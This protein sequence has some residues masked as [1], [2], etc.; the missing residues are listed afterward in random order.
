MFVLLTNCTVITPSDG[1][2]VTV[3]S[4]TGLVN[5]GSFAP[6]NIPLIMRL[7]NVARGQY[8]IW[9]TKLLTPA[10]KSIPAQQLLPPVLFGASKNVVR[11]PSKTFAIVLPALLYEPAVPMIVPVNF[12]AR[13]AIACEE[14]RE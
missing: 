13:L 12:S 9:V 7:T 3:K 6:W 5:P 10:P 2:A 11:F 14:K 4:V 1:W 8:L